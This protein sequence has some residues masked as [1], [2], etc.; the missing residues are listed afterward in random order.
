MCRAFPVVTQDMR[1]PGAAV[2]DW[3]DSK[4]YCGCVCACLGP[5]VLRSPHAALAVAKGAVPRSIHGPRLLLPWVLRLG[6]SMCLACPC[7]CRCAS[8]QSR[9]SVA[10]ALVGAPR[11][12]HV[13]CLSLLW[14]PLIGVSSCL[15]CPCFGR[16]ASGYPHA[17]FAHTFVG[18]HR[19][20]HGPQLPLLWSAR[21]GVSTCLVCPC[22][23]R[24][25]SG[26]PRASFTHAL[27]GAHRGIR[28]LRFP[29]LARASDSALSCRPLPRCPIVPSP[30]RQIAPLSRCPWA[31]AQA[32]SQALPAAVRKDRTPSASSITAPLFLRLKAVDVA[33][34]HYGG[35]GL[36]MTGDDQPVA[37]GGHVIQKRAPI[38]AQFAAG[39]SDMHYG[40]RAE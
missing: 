40:P 25:P 16:C 14:S 30:R 31:R 26:Y 27:V 39:D 34:A 24:R 33:H 5:C 38:L 32:P 2:K 36:A 8:G 28:A 22:F 12:I 23:G 13:P 6:V 37:G 29:S 19:G 7:F 21:L 4:L 18:A 17:S 35:D 3:N 10:F 15:V 11:G 20:S 9:A 1:A